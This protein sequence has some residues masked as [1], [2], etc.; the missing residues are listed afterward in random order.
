M[1]NMHKP[2]HCI[3]NLQPFQRSSLKYGDVR[4]KA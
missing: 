3:C 1:M 2:F 4:L